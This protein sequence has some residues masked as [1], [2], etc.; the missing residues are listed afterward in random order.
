[1]M[2]MR[3]EQERIKATNLAKLLADEELEIQIELAKK[4]T[5]DKTPESDNFAEPV[6][7]AGSGRN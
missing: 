3:D 7:V 5:I 6:A 1:M 2:A 4:S